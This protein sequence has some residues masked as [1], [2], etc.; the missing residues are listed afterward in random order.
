MNDQPLLVGQVV[1]KMK[2]E[3][4]S[5]RLPAGIRIPAERVLA[6]RYGVSR[7]TV[8]AAISR[9][10]QLGFVR[11]VPQSGTFVNDYL[12]VASI[13]L[14]VD[15]MTSSEEVDSA[16]LISLLE[17]RR[18]V[19]VYSAGRAVVRMSDD[20]IDT[21]REM[22]REMEG[23]ADDRNR[24]VDLD[25]QLHSF[26]V[27]NSGNP[28]LRLLFNSFEPI[29][30]FYLTFFYGIPESAD[31]IMR[32]YARLVRAA[33]MR[34]DRYASHIMEELLVYAETSV[35]RAI[36]DSPMIKIV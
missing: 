32:Y 25:Y 27:I 2:Q 22:I 4:L 21:M 33:E 28:V 19:E 17:M 5:G 18:I 26:L 13:D 6:E 12:N 36:D 3:I 23:K 30:R 20:E 1:R 31:I 29:Y 10:A 8:R 24:L 16:I 11:T 7:I 35:K 9:L 34:D 14:L 15:I